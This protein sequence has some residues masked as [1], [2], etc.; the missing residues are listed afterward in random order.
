M[1]A[2]GEPELLRRELNSYDRRLVHLEVGR[3]EGVMTR[4]VG[5]GVDRRIEILPGDAGS[6]GEGAES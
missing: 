6:S 4:S 2:T 5:E 3:I 1:L